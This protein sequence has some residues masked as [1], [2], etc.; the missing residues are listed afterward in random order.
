[1]YNNNI[2]ISYVHI[3]CVS[4]NIFIGVSTAEA[5]LD[6][7][8]GCDRCGW[9]FLANKVCY[10]YCMLC[11][12]YAYACIYL[13]TT[14]MLVLYT[15]NTHACHVQAIWWNKTKLKTYGE[16]FRTGKLILHL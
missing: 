15:Y 10:V 14:Y 3:R 7:Y 4:K 9:G 16:L 6:N 2:S 5:K 8:V 1:M 13:S 12:L 11:I